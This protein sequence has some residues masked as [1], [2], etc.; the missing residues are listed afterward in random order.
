MVGVVLRD[1]GELA[2][3]VSLSFASGFQALIHFVP[4]SKKRGRSS[5]D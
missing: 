3:L 4:Y 2:L 1:G 5:L